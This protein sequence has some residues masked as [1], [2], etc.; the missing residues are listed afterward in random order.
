MV[1]KP[2]SRDI[3]R[4]RR[5]DIIILSTG[6][7]ALLF[8]LTATG[9][10]GIL[11]GVSASLLLAGGAF[12]YHIG[13]LANARVAE[14][15]T[16]IV[17]KQSNADAIRRVQQSLVDALNQPAL[18]VDAG[19]QL[20]AYNQVAGQIFSLPDVRIGLS[21]GSLRNPELLA[22][23]DRVL[24][25]GGAAAC[26]LVPS[27]D[28]SQTWLV[29]ITALGDD[30][31]GERSAL[32][33]L[34][35]QAP[36]RR[37]EKARADFL[38]NASHELRTPLTSISGF[39]ET[40]QGPARDD[41]DAWPKFIQ[42]MAD[43]TTHM[44]D[45]ITDLLSLSRI[46]L[47]EHQAPTTKVD[48]L[49]IVREAAESLVHI[50]RMKSQEIKFDFPEAPVPLIASEGELK[51]VVHNLVGNAIKYSPANTVITVSMGR[52]RDL[53][54]AEAYASRG[55]PEAARSTLLAAPETIGGASRAAAWFRVRDEGAGIDAA[56][57]PRLGERFFRV[58]ESRGGPD[59][60]T[61][62]G[63]AIVK[64]IMAHHRGGFAV[65]S[66]IEEG[67]AFSVWLPAI[68]EPPA[69]N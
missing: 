66:Q 64:H 40:M 59:E 19:A 6:G 17:V 21:A 52:S 31:A 34:T 49:T 35:D 27:R 23:I 24:N 47:G 62:L 33:V 36:V 7:L 37:A 53:D 3:G 28:P 60:G 42:I 68:D 4:L 43:Q 46:E 26:E 2:N 29:T 20:V 18:I 67:T 58:D 61:G 45:L 25:A 54:A 16:K 15:K 55:W 30:A 32:I 50:A 9:V 69:S 56:F 65:E 1:S 51:Q 63:L 44:K 11:E 41:P 57:L 10:L 8:A 39:L 13:I 22:H 14:P 5:Q 12:A 48:F 38:A